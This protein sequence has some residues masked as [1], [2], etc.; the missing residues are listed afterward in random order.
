[1]AITAVSGAVLIE[2]QASIKGTTRTVVDGAT[3][4]AGTLLELADLNT[5]TANNGTGDVW[6]GV[7]MIDKLTGDGSITISADMGPGSVYLMWSH[8]GAVITAGDKVATSGANLIRTATEAEIAS[9]KAIGFAEGTTAEG[10]VGQRNKK[11]KK[12]QE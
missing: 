3:I 10:I 2:S 11:K 7:A 5:V 12:E 4:S 8:R 1:M 6:G 9:G